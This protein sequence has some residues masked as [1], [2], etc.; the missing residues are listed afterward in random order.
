MEVQKGMQAK[1]VQVKEKTLGQ[2]RTHADF[3]PSEDSDIQRIKRMTANLI[4]CVESFKNKTQDEE[5]LRCLTHAQGNFE[6]G[7]MWAVKGVA[8]K[9]S[10]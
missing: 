1:P 3:N 10:E 2:K 5:V 6:N 7:A 4:D 9:F 8:K